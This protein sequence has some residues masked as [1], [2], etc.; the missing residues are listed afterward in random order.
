MQEIDPA[1]SAVVRSVGLARGETPSPEDLL[2]RRGE[3]I[4]HDARR[5]LDGFVVGLASAAAFFLALASTL[6]RFGAAAFGIACA[7]ALAMQVMTARKVS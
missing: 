4:F 6:T 2:R 7:A 5:S 1:A 3:A